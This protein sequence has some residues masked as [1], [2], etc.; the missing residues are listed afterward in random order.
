[1]KYKCTDCG[2]EYDIK[3]EFCDC[4]NNV[5]EEIQDA[6]VENF[7]SVRNSAPITDEKTDKKTYKEFPQKRV[8]IPSLLI[9][10][11][12]IILSILSWIFIGRDI[13]TSKEMTTNEPK[14]ITNK[15]IPDINKLWNDKSAMPVVIPEPV[16]VKVVE[17]SPKTSN[18]APQPAK[19]VQKT[20][21][22]PSKNNN[23]KSQ[24]KTPVTQPQKTVQ[25]VQNTPV[26]TVQKAQ[27]TM[28]EQQKQEIIQKL[29]TKKTPPQKTEPKK[30]EQVKTETQKNVE[31]PK[32]EQIKQEVKQEV[33]MPDA[34]QLKKELDEYKI[35]LRNKLGRAINFSA[36]IGDGKCAVTFKLDQTGNLVNRKF[37]VQSQNNSLND[38][39][40]AAVL[41][42]PTF[43]EPPAG[44]K[45]ETLTLTVTMYG[46][47]FEVKLK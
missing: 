15:Q 2:Q 36:V 32:Q 39:V 38:A 24:V 21:N 12:C 4:G 5:F 45:N 47:N 42:N 29:S 7:N 28:T 20:V 19:T 10:I 46:G 13:N 43:K 26:N 37:A 8:D 41:Q 18:I 35:A 3:P 16:A 31:P 40:Y 1:M 22:S 6:K 17:I 25:Q 14:T 23:S 44:Y 34:A 30:V 9:F 11:T 27:P 33:K